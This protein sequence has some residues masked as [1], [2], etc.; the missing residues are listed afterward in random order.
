MMDPVFVKGHLKFALGDAKLQFNNQEISVF[1]VTGLP[2]GAVNPKE[3]FGKLVEATVTLPGSEKMEFRTKA[4]VMRESSAHAQHMGIKFH[5]DAAQQAELSH[6][7]AKHGHYPTEYIRKYPRI[8]SSSA[9][10]TFPL[11][12]FVSRRG[13]R[14][15]G[16]E[17]PIVLDVQNLSPNGIL[18]ST[19]NQIALAIEP[20]DRLDLIL[21]P[22]GWFP[23]QIRVEGL[24]CRVVDE[25]NAANGNVVR[26][27]G[28]KFTRV[29]EVNRTAFLDL[30]KDIL[31]AI[32]TKKPLEP[33]KT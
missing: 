5:M 3:N 27:L 18:L 32:K 4:Y 33:R 7:I 10:Q 11:K 9:I 25:M 22:R 8:P 13:T 16:A 6:F 19:E 21:D 2:W 23:I 1:G 24:A 31:E 12:V 28:I 29:D 15:P 17:A 14:L 30:L 26:Y 20:G